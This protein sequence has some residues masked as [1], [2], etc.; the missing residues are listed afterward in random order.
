MTDTLE[1]REAKWRYVLNTAR[2]PMSTRDDM[3]TALTLI[4]TAAERELALSLPAREVRGVRKA[5]PIEARH[6]PG[7][8]HSR[9]PLWLCDCPRPIILAT[10][11]APREKLEADLVEAVKALDAAIE[12]E[13]ALIGHLEE[14]TGPRPG[15][16]AYYKEFAERHRAT[17]NRLSGEG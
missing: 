7:C 1:R 2:A 16:A 9:A 4:A 13:L 14:A 10:T 6:A 8:E 5:L 11:P 17:L 12:C 3:R 15:L